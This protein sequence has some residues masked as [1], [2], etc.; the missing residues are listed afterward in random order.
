MICRI[1]I[2]ISYSCI[3]ITSKNILVQINNSNPSILHII[4]VI[5]YNDEFYCFFNAIVEYKTTNPETQVEEINT[6]EDSFIFCY[7]EKEDR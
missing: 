6:K 3:I 2:C 7:K 1:W 5:P 4:D